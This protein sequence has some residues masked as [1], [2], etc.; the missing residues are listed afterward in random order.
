MNIY[1]YYTILPKK[2]ALNY[3]FAF[4][5][6]RQTKTPSENI[7]ME[8]ILEK[9]NLGDNILLKIGWRILIR[10]EEEIKIMPVI[11]EKDTEK[12]LTG[13]D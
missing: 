11:S 10:G 7:V 13:A 4:I 8:E 2:E 1:S 3:E 12:S 6:T 9:E 5:Q